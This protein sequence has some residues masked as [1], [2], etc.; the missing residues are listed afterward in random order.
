MPRAPSGAG[1]GPGR[2]PFAGLAQ[3]MMRHS[4]RLPRR[5]RM[6]LLPA[7]PPEAA[8]AR[9]GRWMSSPLRLRTRPGQGRR[10]PGAPAS[11]SPGE[12]RSGGEPRTALRRAR[13][14]SKRSRARISLMVQPSELTLDSRRRLGRL[15]SMAGRLLGIGQL[16]APPVPRAPQTHTWLCRQIGVLR[17]WAM[18]RF[19]AS[20]VRGGLL[21]HGLARTS[22]RR[23]SH[24]YL[25]MPGQY[26][27]ARHIT[28]RFK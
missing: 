1:F 19:G 10:P 12:V 14:L 9:R 18:H 11:A 7:P 2:R 3:D 4:G 27:R 21:Y 23:P 5:V 8:S 22:P 13:L 15:F 16:A 24:R 28:F 20:R 17:S 6:P 26:C 25:P